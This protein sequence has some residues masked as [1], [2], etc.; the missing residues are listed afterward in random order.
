LDYIVR[1]F[2]SIVLLAALSCGV[3]QAGLLAPIV[4]FGAPRAP[5]SSYI[6]PGDVVSSAKAWYG[7]R[8][9]NRAY[10]TGSNPAVDLCDAATGLTCSTINILSNGNFDIVT[11]AAAPACA[12]ACVVSKLY[13]QT[14][15]GYHLKSFSPTKGPAYLASGQNGYPVMVFTGVNGYY[16]YNVST[17]SVAQP[18]TISAVTKR[19]GNFTSNGTIFEQAASDNG[20][21]FYGSAN[22][23]N[24]YAGTSG[25]FTAADSAWH[26]VQGIFSGAASTANV[27]GSAVTVNAGTGAF[28]NSW[29]I[30]AGVQVYGN[31]GEVGI[32]PSGFSSAQQ[33][34]VCHNE[35]AYWATSASC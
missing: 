18:F 13:D 12:V 28:G 34:N 14:G 35:Y 26:A 9:Y 4:N 21:W 11:A 1:K 17:T 6:G 30:S 32:W 7:F 10:A 20:L 16:L 31:I 2:L 3:A 15:N 19:T 22:T 23:M 5:P 33:T 8:G 25:T 27:D 29:D 24:L